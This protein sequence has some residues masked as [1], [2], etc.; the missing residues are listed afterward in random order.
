[1]ILSEKERQLVSEV[2]SIRNSL[3]N[4]RDEAALTS[5]QRDLLDIVIRRLW[6]ATVEYGG[7]AFWKSEGEASEG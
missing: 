5:A 2:R 4:L 3:M 7:E 6:K 1:M